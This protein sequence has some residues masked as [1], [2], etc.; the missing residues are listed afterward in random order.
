MRSRYP[1]LY[2]S[3]VIAIAYY[4]VLTSVCDHET[5]ASDVKA[6]ASFIYN[7]VLGCCHKN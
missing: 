1:S 2:S 5:Y 6:I 7:A 3:T 4:S